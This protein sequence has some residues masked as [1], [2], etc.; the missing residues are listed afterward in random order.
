MCGRSLAL[1]IVI[2]SAGLD[3]NADARR[4]STRLTSFDELPLFLESQ[5]GWI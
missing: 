5:L 2:L 3:I 1:Y 4:Q